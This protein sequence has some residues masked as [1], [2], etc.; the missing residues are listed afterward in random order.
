MK[1]INILKFKPVALDKKTL[2]QNKVNYQNFE[3]TLSNLSHLTRS[4]ENCKRN[5]GSFSVSAI[6]LGSQGVV[7][8]C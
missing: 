2:K 1:C 7:R 3:K 6:L 5:L 8:W 4:L